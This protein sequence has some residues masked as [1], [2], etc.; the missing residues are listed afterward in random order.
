M[1]PDFGSVI[2]A[3]RKKL[4]DGKDL[5]SDTKMHGKE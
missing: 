4:S 2:I 3:Q 5:R 1:F